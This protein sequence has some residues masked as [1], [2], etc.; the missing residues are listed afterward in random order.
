MPCARLSVQ[1]GRMGSDSECELESNIVNNVAWFS[2]SG[3]NLAISNLLRVDCEIGSKVF[4]AL[5]YHQFKSPERQFGAF[6]ISRFYAA[7][8]LLG[9]SSLTKQVQIELILKNLVCFI[10][11]FFDFNFRMLS[12]YEKLVNRLVRYFS[13]HI[14]FIFFKKI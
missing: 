11:G 2:S 1:Y 6:F 13:I 3:Y 9:K 5:S 14:F 8:I 12:C 4:P 10:I 7:A